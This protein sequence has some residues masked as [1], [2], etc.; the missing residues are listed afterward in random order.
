MTATTFAARVIEFYRQLRPPRLDGL[1]VQALLP[2]R[3][4]QARACTDLFYGKYFKDT[5]PRV[6]LIGINPGRFGAG[7]TGVPFTDPVSLEK[8]GIPN[9]FPK[10]RELSAV[11]IESLIEQ[12]GGP[13]KFYQ[14]FFITAAS[15]VGFTKNG[16]NYNYY[17][18]R[19]LLT[20]GATIHREDNAR[21]AR[22]R[23]SAR[24][25]AGTGDWRELR[26]PE[27]VERGG[28]LFREAPRRRTPA[29]H[30]AVPA[31]AGR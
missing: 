27:P 3:V 11:F 8:I 17:D 29:V 10:R 12:W 6:F 25:G 14:T 1:G 7:T 26:V 2:Y 15:P 22:V 13:E 4:L 9:P 20:A 31:K 24:C 28:G 30:H 21:A 23:R 5:S 19:K 16:K 18:D